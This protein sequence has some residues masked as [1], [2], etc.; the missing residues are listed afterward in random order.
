MPPQLGSLEL[1]KYR[2]DR[3]MPY[4]TTASG[5]PHFSL[6]T[7]FS[8]QLLPHEETLFAAM[9]EHIAPD[10]PPLVNA[11]SYCGRYVSQKS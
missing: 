8:S 4:M 2:R 10:A 9:Y 3:C 5:R 6:I 7:S 11:A 1:T